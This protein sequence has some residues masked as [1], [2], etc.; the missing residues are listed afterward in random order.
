MSDLIV[1]KFKTKS[2]EISELPVKEILEI[3]GKPY[4]AASPELVANVAH[5]QG[6]IDAL[7]SQQIHILSLIG[8]SHS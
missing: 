3:D 4:G 5:L 8:G 2:G 6:Q 7:Q 1:I